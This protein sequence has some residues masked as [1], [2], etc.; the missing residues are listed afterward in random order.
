[1]RAAG[2]S[3][4]MVSAQGGALKVHIKTRRR[5]GKKAARVQEL[6]QR[7]AL[8]VLQVLDEH[9]RVIE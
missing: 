4:A 6:Q 3:A 9:G 1:M 5:P 2:L 7:Q 8:P